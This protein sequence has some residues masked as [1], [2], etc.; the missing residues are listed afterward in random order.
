MIDANRKENINACQTALT[1]Q[2]GR[3]AVLLAEV[4][5]D[6]VWHMNF[7]QLAQVQNLFEVAVCEKHGLPV[8]SDDEIHYALRT[9]PVVN[10]F[11]GIPV[12]LNRELP[13]HL[14]ALCSE[15][16]GQKTIVHA[17]IYNLAIPTFFHER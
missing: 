7:G 17:A 2:L 15:R 5:V 6:L 1:P 16:R 14:V 8:V 4:K 10:I 3:Q 11:V 12:V 13:Q 9:R